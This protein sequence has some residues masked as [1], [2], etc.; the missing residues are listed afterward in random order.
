MTRLITVLAIALTLSV[1]GALGLARQDAPDGPAAAAVVG[2][3]TAG[4]HGADLAEVVAGLQARLEQ[5]PGDAPAWATLALAYV[6]QA[7]TSGDPTLYTRATAAVARS[8]EEQP[9]D[10]AGALA[11]AAAIA[12]ARHKFSVALAYARQA[13]AIDPYQPGALAIRVD[14]LTELGRYAAQLRALRQADHRQPGLPIV[15]R[16]SYAF[17]LRGQ[18]ARANHVLEGAGAA[19]A[20]RAF[21]LT[22][23]ADLDRRRGRLDQAAAHLR[24]ALRA[25]PDYVPAMVSRARLATAQ[26]RTDAAVRRWED[27]VS[28]LP[29]PEYLIELGEL[30]LSLGQDARATEEFD[31]VVT[32]TQLLA[33]S[34]VNT[35]LESALFEADHGSP[36]AA[37][38]AARTEWRRRQ[39]IHVADVL[40][41]ALHRTGHDQQALKYTRLATRLGTAEGRLWLHRGTI[42]AALGLTDRARTHLRYGLGVDPGLSP[43]QADQGRAALRTLGGMR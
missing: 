14:A 16:Y 5:V 20:E 3:A 32:T 36:A 19:P 41:W 22:L 26:G 15:T 27:V 29:L 39:S 17:E 35:D 9:D 21:V 4:L 10:N 11:A 2:D 13:L 25:M 40:A 31:V 37:L 38:Q 6:E 33:Q 23:Q 7:R 1:A 24:T 18:L 12:A 42:E 43:W 28:R 30:R 34:G 8:M